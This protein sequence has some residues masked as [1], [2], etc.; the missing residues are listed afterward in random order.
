MVA[1][2]LPVGR[3]KAAIVGLIDPYVL[4]GH[5]LGLPQKAWDQKTAASPRQR[6]GKPPKVASV[7]LF[8]ASD[9]SSCM[10]GTVSEDTGGR[11]M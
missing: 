10:P 9:L 6:A 1:S 3:S 5:L 2:R 8:Y 11:F 4:V 7:P